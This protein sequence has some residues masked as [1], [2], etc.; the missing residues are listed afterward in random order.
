MFDGSIASIT[1]NVCRLFGVGNPS[2][3]EEPAVN[4]V[5]EHA[6][7][8]LGDMPLERCLIYCPDALGDQIWSKSAEH[9]A[10]IVACAAL[11][12]HVS[13]VVPPKTPVCFASVFTGAPPQR[14]GIR[15]YERPVLTCD[16]LFDALLRAEKR[17]AIVAVRD[18][19]IDLLFRGRRIDYFSETYDREVTERALAVIAAD[20]HHL[21]VVYHQ[22]Y[23][24]L[25]H[26]THPHSDVC[27]QAVAHHVQSFEI[28]ARAAQRGWSAHNRAIIFAPDHGAHTDPATGKGDHGLDVPEDMSLRHWYGIWRGFPG[29]SRP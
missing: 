8:V 20:T 9:V 21:V 27:M 14:H 19:S 26:K 15:K 3:V 29:D 24:D 12:L 5:V 1:P 25:L 7:G 11:Q 2:L 6:S 17:V 10:T 28:L 22:E 16:T 18:S 13:S 23:D 4:A